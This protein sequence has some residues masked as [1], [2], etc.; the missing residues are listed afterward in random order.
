MGESGSGKPTLLNGLAGHLPLDIG[1]VIFDTCVE[2]PVDIVTMSEPARRMLSR[3]DWAFVHKNARDGLCMSVS[4]GGNI[5]ERLMAVGGRH[6]GQIR[7][8]A[9]DWLCRVEIDQARVDDWPSSFS[10][11]CSSGCMLCAIW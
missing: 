3:T 8:E 6:Y 1:Q 4:A 5:G 10:R 11:V 2:G 9:V 7:K